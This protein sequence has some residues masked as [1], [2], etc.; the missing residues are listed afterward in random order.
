M[1]LTEVQQETLL[2]HIEATASA[3][4]QMLAILQEEFES[5]QQRN[6][7]TP[8]L[9]TRK[10]EQAEQLAAHQAAIETLHAS[11][12]SGSSLMQWLDEQ[13]AKSQFHAN[14]RGLQTILEQCDYKNTVNGQ[15]LNRLRIKN[16]LFQR[17]L[18]NHPADPTYSRSGKLDDRHH[19]VLGKA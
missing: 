19:G 6:I 8:E 18:G 10:A 16:Q 5:L 9:L 15:L 11:L 17:I 13:P 2:R 14:W 3:A 1:S 7:P 4:R 12:S